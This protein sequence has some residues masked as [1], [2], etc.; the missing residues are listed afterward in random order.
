MNAAYYNE[1]DPYAAQWLRNLIAAGHIP[2]GDVDERSIEL[3]RPDDLRTYSA[4][5]FF[6]GIGG[7][8]YAGAGTQGR[9]GGPNLQTAASWATPTGRD[10]KGGASTL[11]N[12]PVNALLGRQVLGMISSGSPAAMARRGQ[13]NPAFSRWLQ[14]YPEEW[15]HAAPSKVNRGSAC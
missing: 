3:V 12:T 5:H 9:D 14:G 7:W 4:C 8:P 1:I 13:L 15:D 10:H 6:A 2:A 11:E